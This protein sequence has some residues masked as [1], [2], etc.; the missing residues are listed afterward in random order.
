[1]LNGKK[2]W[3][4]CDQD[5][6]RFRNLIAALWF[7][8]LLP[9]RLESFVECLD[10]TDEASNVQPGGAGDF[11]CI[12]FLLLGWYELKGKFACLVE[13]SKRTSRKTQ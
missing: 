6:N 2:R 12:K 11:F 10:T 13:L 7:E 8:F 5:Y 4:K 3:Y 1:M 9:L